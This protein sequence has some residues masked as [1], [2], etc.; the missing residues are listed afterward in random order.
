[1]IRVSLRYFELKKSNQ[2]R[3]RDKHIWYSK[4]SPVRG[5][6]EGQSSVPCQI[7]SCKQFAE[8]ML[9]EHAMY[10]T[11]VHNGTRYKEFFSKHL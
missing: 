11:H 7:T 4:V 8:L 2:I 3:D 1:M 6:K 5:H 10:M 9:T